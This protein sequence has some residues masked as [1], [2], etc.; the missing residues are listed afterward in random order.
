M[1]SKTKN[2]ILSAFLLASLTACKEEPIAVDFLKFQ[3]DLVL[4]T[5]ENNTGEDIYSIGFEITYFTSDHSIID[6]DTLKFSKTSDPE[7]IQK[8][9]VEAGSETFFSYSMP[10]NTS[11]ASARAFEFSFNK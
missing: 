5:V 6:V 2:T 3:N 7:G 9:F 4:F 11:S 1:L 8:P 10:P